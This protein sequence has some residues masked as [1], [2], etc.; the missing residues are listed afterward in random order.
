MSS[1]VQ[2]CRCTASRVS[3]RKGANESVH[4]HMRNPHRVTADAFGRE[5]RP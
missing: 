5:V 4:M 2:S 1:R 3:A